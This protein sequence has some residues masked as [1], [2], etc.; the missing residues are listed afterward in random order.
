M[1]RTK[2]YQLM[3][4]VGGLAVGASM[5]VLAG[6]NGNSGGNNSN[7]GGGNSSDSSSVTVV[8]LNWT[9][10]KAT[11]DGDYSEWNLSGGNVMC[12]AGSINADGTGCDGNG[13]AHLSTVYLRYDCSSSTMYVL[14]LKEEG[15]DAQG[16][17]WVKIYDSE[18]GNSEYPITMAD[19][20]VDGVSLGYEA[21]FS[22]APDTTYNDVQIHMNVSENTSSTGKN[23]FTRSI[24]VGECS[25]E[26]TLACS[27]LE[28]SNGVPMKV[29]AEYTKS[30][31]DGGYSFVPGSG[32]NIITIDG[33][34]NPSVSG[35]AI[36]IATFIEDGVQDSDG[37]VSGDN[38]QFC[39]V[40]VFDSAGAEVCLWSADKDAEGNYINIEQVGCVD[41]EKGKF[42]AIKAG[43]EFSSA[44]AAE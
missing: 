4:V 22:L 35:D 25:E 42:Y 39:Q 2:L 31:G 30:D 23:G 13:K 43:D 15:Y 28:G 40:P 9:A 18:V 6:G 44:L 32:T 20:V 27:D 29:I 41:A 14:V 12:T 3:A 24:T 26:P 33:S 1:R 5:P 10:G 16:E 8:P 34:G 11:V 36:E 7:A 21:S 38:I 37:V 17:R 19:V